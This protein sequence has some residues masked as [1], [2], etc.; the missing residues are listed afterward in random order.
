ML[1]DPYIQIFFDLGFIFISHL[2]SSGEGE[3]GIIAGALQQMNKKSSK[4]FFHS[5]KQ[6]VGCICQEI[7]CF[8]GSSEDT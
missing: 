8:E 3:G 6:V 7:Y 5:S 4:C 1:H 2:N